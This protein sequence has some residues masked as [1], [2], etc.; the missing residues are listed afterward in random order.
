MDLICDNIER[1]KKGH[2]I[3]ERELIED[4]VEEAVKVIPVG[5]RDSLEIGEPVSVSLEKKEEE[6]AKDEVVLMVGKV[7]NFILVCDLVEHSKGRA[8]LCSYVECTGVIR[9]MLMFFCKMLKEGGE[10]AALVLKE[11]ESWLEMLSRRVKR[12]D[13]NERWIWALC[14]LGF[15]RGIQVFQGL[16]KKWWNDECSDK[17]IKAFA[18]D[19]VEKKAGK[20]ILRQEINKIS[21]AG[22][23]VLGELNVKGSLV[24]GEITAKYMQDEVELR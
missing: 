20:L 2:S 3:E 4:G 11:E 12:E 19:F 21:N 18:L 7:L 22:R 24:S 14:C 1:I 6:P 10:G 13:V 23:S 8:L 17:V 9:M 15:S 5:I 16:S